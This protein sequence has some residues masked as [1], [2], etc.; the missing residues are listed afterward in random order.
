MKIYRLIAASILLAAII[1]LPAY[2]QQRPAAQQPQVAAPAASST[3]PVPDSKVALIDTDAFA[4]EKAGILRLVSAV[5]RVETEFTPRKTEL[6]GIQTRIKALQDE[7]AKVTGAAS[8]IDPKTIQQKKEQAE[9][10]QREFDFKA[11]GAQSDY[12]KRLQEVVGPIYDDIRKALDAFARQRGITLMLD[13]AKI[14]PA[15]ITANAA[16]DITSAFIAEFNSK[17]PATASAAAPR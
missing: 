10:L 14:G 13:A 6:Q 11:Q 16:M 12:N 3:A 4:D 7:V 8:V 17:N 9:S 2:A 15:I 5:K 1:A